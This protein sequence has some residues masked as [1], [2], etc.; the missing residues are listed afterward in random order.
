MARRRSV[1]S[2]ISSMI[3]T[4]KQQ[5]EAAVLSSPLAG[6]AVALPSVGAASLW[7]TWPR[8]FWLFLAGVI[9]LYAPT[10]AHAAYVWS[11]NDSYAHG[12]I[13][14][15]VSLYLIWNQRERIAR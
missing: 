4:E 3:S 6:D 14:L 9:A 5:P 13:V 1:P 12:F 10:L 15:P 11:T 2:S 8:S 7:L